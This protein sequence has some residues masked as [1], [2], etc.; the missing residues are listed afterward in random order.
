VRARIAGC[1]YVVSVASALTNEALVHGT[2]LYVV[3]LVPILCFLIA[4]VLLYQVFKPVNGV[5][6][7]LAACS[8]IVS[9]GFEAAEIH[10]GGVNAGLAFHGLYCALLGFLA[11]KSGFVPRILGVSAIAAGLGWLTNISSELE[12]QVAPYDTVVGFIGEGAL[13]LWLL[14]FGPSTRRRAASGTR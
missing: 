14:A 6:A 12:Q 1:L 8:N 9:L 3:S 11:I 7:L 5:V 10:P 4:T 2:L 13:M